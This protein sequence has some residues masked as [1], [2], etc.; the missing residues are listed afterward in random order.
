V[1]NALLLQVLPGVSVHIAEGLHCRLSAP[2]F[3]NLERDHIFQAY[4]WRPLLADGI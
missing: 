2:Q 1:L 4:T 3:L